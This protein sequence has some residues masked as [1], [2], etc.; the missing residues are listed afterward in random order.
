MIKNIASKSFPIAIPNNHEKL[1]ENKVQ[2]NYRTGF[3]TI[4]GRPNVGKSTLLNQLVG[5]KVSITS[6]KAQT[7]RHRINGILTDQQAQFVFVDTPGYQTQHLSQLNKLMNHSVKQSLCEVDVV[8]FVIEALHFD[9][10]DNL[11]E[12]ILPANKPVILVINK[13]DKLADREKLLPFIAQI[14]KDNA[15]ASIVPVSAELKIQL[16][17]LID[18]IRSYLPEGNPLFNEDVVT[19]RNERFVAA[20]VLREKLFR[21]MGDEIPYAAS[22]IVDHFKHDGNLRKIFVS[23][24]VGNANQKAMVI[25]KNGQKIKI[26]AEQTRKELEIL[27][28]GKVFLDVWIKVKSGWADDASVLKSLGY[29]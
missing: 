20:E 7:T 27:F 18:T 14:A 17:I 22:V 28:G 9:H 1:L 24:L 5:H 15:Y 3:V 8:I 16:S 23:I 29:E 6:K 12:K 21:M 26:M 25:G 11:V 4:V 13:I 10:R 19:D 2:T